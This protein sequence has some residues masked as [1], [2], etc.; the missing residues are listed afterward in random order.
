[1][2][3]LILVRHCEPEDD[4]RGLCYGRLDIGLS[5]AGR[6]HAQRLAAGLARLE[7]D[8]VYA[9]PRVRARET[10]HAVAGARDVL[11]DEGLR[12]LDF[13][14]LE[15]RSYDEIAASDP[16]ESREWFR[17]LRE[18]AETH[19]L[20]ELSMGTTQDYHVAAE[21]GATYVRVGA[22]LFK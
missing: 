12:E 6:E 21:E 1:M 11:V 5:D 16:E 7:W 14:E 3:R 10:A 20:T 18:L 8:A 9:S 17:R 15:G 13:G 19:G 22:V 2:S 4:A